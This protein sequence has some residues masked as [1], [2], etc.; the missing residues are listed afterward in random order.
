M[1]DP[2]PRPTPDADARIFEPA[3]LLPTYW[4]RLCRRMQVGASIAPAEQVFHDLTMVFG[5]LFGDGL[6]GYFEHSHAEFDRQ[7]E[8]LSAHGFADVASELERARVLMFGEQALT[9]EMV[10]DGIQAYFDV[11]E[12][13][14]QK[15]EELDELLEG[16]YPRLH[17]VA[18][19]RNAMGIREGFYER[20]D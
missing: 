11:E 4:E 14:D 17:A 1:P 15:N 6:A 2:K 20:L 5:G 3:Q 7:M 13:G 10:A 12:A 9:E 8:T 19:Y 16:L 18:D